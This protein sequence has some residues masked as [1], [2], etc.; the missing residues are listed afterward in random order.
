MG[1]F[2]DFAEAKAAVDSFFQEARDAEH[3]GTWFLKLADR[4]EADP[5]RCA[6]ILR[7]LALY[8]ADNLEDI[9]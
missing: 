5:K 2:K 3:S 6:A 4:V 8:A 7:E 1:M 9:T